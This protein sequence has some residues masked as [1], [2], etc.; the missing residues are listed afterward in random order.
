MRAYVGAWSRK[1]GGC[2]RAA[3]MRHDAARELRQGDGV[4]QGAPFDERSK[5]MSTV[6]AVARLGPGDRLTAGEAG[7]R[8]LPPPIASWKAEIL[9]KFLESSRTKKHKNAFFSKRGP[10]SNSIILPDSATFV[11]LDSKFE[12]C[13]PVEAPLPLIK[14]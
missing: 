13:E 11:E 1:Q 14:H 7:W 9:W 6:A 8:V 10:A 5:A 3:A 4:W 2:R 12:S